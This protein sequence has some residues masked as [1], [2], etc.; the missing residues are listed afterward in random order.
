V[1]RTTARWAA[2]RPDIRAVAV[3]GS[4][5]RGEATETSDLDVIVITDEVDEYVG[6]DTWVLDA[7]GQ[8]GRTV[9][10]RPWGVLSEQR[11]LLA[12]SF[13]VE[14]GFARASWADSSPPDAGTLDVVR[15][16]LSIL[17]DP[18]GLLA[19]LAGVAGVPARHW[20]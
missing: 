5:A 16:G 3:V 10:S 6:A 8:R 11:V 2:G 15:K 4:W 18:D 20:R 19:V 17:Y 12:S 13:E 1:L 14:F 9:R 7:T